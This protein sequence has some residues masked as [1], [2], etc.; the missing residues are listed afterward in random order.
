M[1]PS[2]ATRSENCRSPDGRRFAAGILRMGR[3]R[4]SALTLLCVAMLMTL[5]DSDVV[6]QSGFPSRPVVTYSAAI[7]GSGYDE[8][9]AVAVDAQGAIYV[10]GVSMSPD[11][12]GTRIGGAGG[13]GDVFVAKLDP[14]GQTVLFLSVFGGSHTEEVRGLAVDT[15][16]RLHVAGLTLSTDFPVVNPI[17]GQSAAPGGSNGFIATVSATGGSLLFSSYLGGSEADEAHGVAAGPDNVIVV[18]GETRSTDFPVSSARQPAGLGLDGFV[19]KISAGGALQWSTYHGGQASDSLFGVS[20]DATGHIA[21]AGTTNS[22]DYPLLHQ[23]QGPAG[24][25]DA[26][27]SRFT[28]S[29]TLTFSTLLG[30]AALDAAQAV[31]TDAGGIVYVAGTTGSANFPATPGTGA[32]GAGLDA[33]ATSYTSSGALVQSVRFGGTAM[34]RARAIAAD[35]TGLYVSGQTVSADFPLVRPAQ[36]GVA[37]NRDAFVVMLRGGATIYSTYVGTSGND[38]ASGMALDGVGRVAIAGALQV[39]GSAS[40]GPADAFLFRLSS[41]DE[42]SDTDNDQ[43]PDAWETQFNLDPRRSDASADPDGDGLTNLQEYQQG[44]HPL[45]HYV[46]YLAEGATIAPFETS[47][48]L[49]NPTD[50]ATAVLIRFLCQRACGVP[51]IAGQDAIVRRLITL[52][53]FARGTLVVSDVPGLADE[54]FAAII[55]AD[56]PVVVDRTMTWDTTAYGSHTETAM[57][58]PAST[59]YLAE[60]ATIN[61]FRLFYLLQNPN[62]EPATVSVEYLLGGGQPPVTATYMLGPHSRTTLDVSTQHPALRRAEVSARI[63]TA[64]E[65]PVLVERAMYLNAGNRLFGAG[66][67]SAGITTP[68]PAWSF[69]EGATGP[70]FDT[71]LLLANPW[72][73]PL[74]V[75]ATFLLPTGATIERHYDVAPKSRFNIWV[76]QAAPELENTA[77]ST[78]L[79]SVD[80]RSFVAERAM[81]WPGPSSNNW[82]EAH[83]SPGSLTTSARWGLAEGFLGGPAATETYVLVANT[84]PFGGT[85]RVTLSFEDDG[86]RLTRDYSVAANSRANVPMRE[87]FPQATGRRFGVLVESLGAIPAQLVVERAMYSDSGRDRWAAG[88]NALGTP[89]V[90]DRVIT[91]TAHGV[92]PRVLVV[93]PGEQVT[94][95]NLDTVSHQ[96]FSA[97]HLERSQCPPLNQIGFLAPG[98][99]RSSGNFTSPGTCAFLDDVRPGQQLN[100]AFQGYVIVR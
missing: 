19:T 47:L 62:A 51:D 53:P 30:G 85:A 92:T 48:A 9:T 3:L 7:G 11:L 59:W 46:R 91:I 90:T 18:V 17:A 45:G 36:P 78:I 72:T 56:Q 23:T 28:P 37:G 79:E 89:L 29:G 14:T 63:T 93:S 27:V 15:A 73:E 98:E 69:A 2:G 44:T 4:R 66:H 31:A 16:G 12:P 67:S 74:T 5:R 21:V 81:W 86:S 96:I 94:I 68:A 13:Q 60:G 41:G 88:T 33:F 58:A 61:G 77:V 22:S 83:N 39:S 71:F 100:R 10:A 35:T 70:Y 55:E 43:L 64:P 49:F 82:R 24:G 25:F 32:P 95:R 65:T 40:R 54:E 76:D 84:S 42:G 57:S 26:T 34:D 52:A 1:D 8:A 87:D 97:P 20:I 6:A 38:D 75:R 80:D 99:S 50:K